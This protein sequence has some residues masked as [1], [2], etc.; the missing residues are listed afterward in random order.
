MGVALFSVA[1]APAPSPG[2]A[3]FFELSRTAEPWPVAS[4]AWMVETLAAAIGKTR[5]TLAAGVTTEIFKDEEVILRNACGTELRSLAESC[6]TKISSDSDALALQTFCTTALIA[7][8][9][10][11]EKYDG[12]AARFVSDTPVVRIKREDKFPV[13]LEFQHTENFAK[14]VS[15][16]QQTLIN[17]LLKTANIVSIVLDRK[18]VRGS[19]S[20]RAW[21][22]V[23][24]GIDKRV[25]GDKPPIASAPTTSRENYFIDL[26][27]IG[28]IALVK[29]NVA[30][31]N[32]RLVGFK[33][34]FVAREG[35]AVMARHVKRLALICF[36]AALGWLMFGALLG[37]WITQYFFFNYTMSDKYLIRNFSL[38]ACSACVGTWVSFA[39]RKPSLAFPDLANVDDDMLRPAAR[40]AFVICLTL[41]LALFLEANFVHLDFNSIKIKVG[42]VALV[43]LAFG[44]VCGLAERALGG[45][46]SSD[47]QRLLN[48]GKPGAPQK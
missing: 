16:D 12:A 17:D 18:D 13:G 32:N 3:G 27:A 14:G 41:F 23:L 8:G 44:A 31:A 4:D 33:D 34:I 20:A 24:D 11:K 19:R 21:S 1:D 28:Q 25:Q 46:V 6:A 37:P 30:Y 7:V 35:D 42:D 10:L 29:D 5:D 9:A 43:A 26:Q 22:A 39:L 15:T 47:A 38:A 48:G 2:F 40:V 36:S 45:I